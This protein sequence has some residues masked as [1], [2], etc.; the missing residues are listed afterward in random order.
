MT[1]KELQKKVIKVLWSCNT[2]KQLEAAVN[3]AN[4]AT[5]TDITSESFQDRLDF[6]LPLERC[7][8]IRKHLVNNNLLGTEL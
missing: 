6:Y 5:K 7:H 1:S 4:L 2:L 3:Y 8:A